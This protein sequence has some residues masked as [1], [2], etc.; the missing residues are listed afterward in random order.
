MRFQVRRAAEIEQV[1]RRLEA[2]AA[3]VQML[4][5]VLVVAVVQMIELPW[6]VVVVMA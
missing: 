1:C 5:A 6:E 2:E 4:V 3:V